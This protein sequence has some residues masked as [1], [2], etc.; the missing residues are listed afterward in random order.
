MR[1]AEGMA[2]GD[3]CKRKALISKPGQSVVTGKKAPVSPVLQSAHSLE[4]RLQ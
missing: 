4:Y 3:S 2:V 1:S